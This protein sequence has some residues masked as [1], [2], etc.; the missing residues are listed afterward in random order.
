MLRT[1]VGVGDSEVAS[2]LVGVGVTVADESSF[3]VI[4][5]VAIG[6]SDIVTTMG[7]IKETIVVVL[8]V[9]QV[10]REVD[11]VNP[12]VRRRLYANRV[13]NIGKNLGDSN[14]SD[15]DVALVLD[16]EADTRKA[17]GETSVMLFYNV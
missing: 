15:N 13:A 7:N 5:D 17:C 4:M 16:V 12:D 8:V 6:E 3:K 2:V 9:I 11:V 14:V 10:A 1:G